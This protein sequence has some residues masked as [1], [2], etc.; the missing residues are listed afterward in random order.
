MSSHRVS[1]G[2]L[3]LESRRWRG[4]LLDNQL[5]FL[6]YAVDRLLVAVVGFV[7][8]DGP[9]LQLRPID[10]VPAPRSTY[11]VELLPHARGLVMASP[12]RLPRRLSDLQV[13]SSPMIG[14]PSLSTVA[15]KPLLNIFLSIETFSSSENLPSAT[16]TMTLP[17]TAFTRVFK[18]ADS[19]PSRA[20]TTE[21]THR[22]SAPRRLAPRIVLLA[23]ATARRFK[24]LEKLEDLTL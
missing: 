8:D 5:N 24:L 14:L 16:S 17:S 18:A 15:T 1:I 3:S 9:P 21:V 2:Y 19:S 22:N 11:R 4:G 6:V 20:A 23:S 10:L 13:D 12:K 7:Q